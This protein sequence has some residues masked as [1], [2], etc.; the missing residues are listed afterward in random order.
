MVEGTLDLTGD[1]I[2]GT[3]QY[4]SPEQCQGR[5]D[6]TPASDQY[7]LGVVLYEMVTGRVP[8]QAET[9]LAVILMQINGSELP[10]PLTLRPDLPEAAE[11]VIF[12][13]LARNPADRYPSCEAL[14]RPS[15]RPSA[16][17]PAF[18]HAHRPHLLIPLFNP[19]PARGQPNQQPI[20]TAQ[21]SKH[22]SPHLPAS[23]L[24]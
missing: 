4:M 11:M 10:P 8:F 3:P 21:W 24:P 6:L 13:A 23:P 12:K 1:A 19:P 18:P 17:N 7:S 2:L 5:K 14:A 20:P 16:T 9:P 15:H 22:R